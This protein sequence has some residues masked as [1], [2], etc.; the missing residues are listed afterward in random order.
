[1]AEVVPASSSRA[2]RR[3]VDVDSAATRGTSSLPIRCTTSRSRWSRCCSI[4]RSTPAAASCSSFAAASSTVPRSSPPCR[5]AA[6]RRSCRRRTA[7]PAGR[8]GGAA[9]RGHADRTVVISEKRSGGRPSRPQASAIRRCTARHSSGSPETTLYS[10]A[11]R[12]ARST[13]PRQ[14][15]PPTISGGLGCCTGLG[16]RGSGRAGSGCRRTRILLAPLAGDDLELLLQHRHPLGHG[17][18]RKPVDLVLELVPAGAQ[19]QLNAAAGDVV[20][21]GGRVRHQRGM[22]ERHRRHHRAQP[23]PRGAR[24]QRRQRRP[25]VVRAAPVQAV[26]GQVVIRAK[27]R[28]QP[29]RLAGVGQG[30]PVRPGDVL[31]ALDHQAQLHG[32]GCYRQARGR[33]GDGG[34]PARQAG[35]PAY[36][37]GG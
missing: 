3:G 16:G 4:A 37:A 12:A 15:A 18:E 20:D 29:A 25:G 21:G 13:V 33:G 7:R 1:M 6:A 2:R 26:A 27:Q 28:R 19:P 35:L 8:R 24:G 17:R 30:H 10:C 32:G 31:L 5:P 14:P 34:H 22:P 23:D 36:P 9:R 11:K